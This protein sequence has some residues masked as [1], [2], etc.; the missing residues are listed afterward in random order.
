M[1]I[2]LENYWFNPGGSQ[3]WKY[4]SSPGVFTLRGDPNQNGSI[5]TADARLVLRY[6][7]GDET[8]SGLQAIVSDVDGGG[9]STGDSRLILRYAVGLET[10]FPLDL[11]E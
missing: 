2:C 11:D 7:I 9:I 5:T 8:P 3:V 6:A 10:R 1:R 4:Q